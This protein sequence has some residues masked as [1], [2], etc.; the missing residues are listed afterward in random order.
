MIYRKVANWFKKSEPVKT[1]DIIKKSTE[2]LEDIGVYGTPEDGTK[3]LNVDEPQLYILYD[4]DLYPWSAGGGGGVKPIDLQ[5][6]KQQLEAEIALKQ[7]LLTAGVGIDITSA[8]ISAQIIDSLVSTSADKSL[9]ANQGRELYELIKNIT[10]RTKYLS[11]WDCS[12]GLPITDPPSGSQDYQTGNFFLIEKVASAGGTNYRPSGNRY[13]KDVP[14]TEVETQ[15]VEPNMAYYYDGTNWV[16]T[17]GNVRDIPWTDIVGIPKHNLNLATE[18]NKL[19]NFVDS[20]AEYKGSISTF[21]GTYEDDGSA[22]T[23]NFAEVEE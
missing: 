15:P 4:G 16:L 14:S 8:V 13:E 18:L 20:D 2:T 17:S 11:H 10:S 9:S 21:T 1:F 19:L 23:I 7:D 22:F 12:T 5:L 3:V 6:L